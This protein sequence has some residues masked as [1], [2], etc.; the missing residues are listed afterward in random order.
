MLFSFWQRDSASQ[1][2]CTHED[3]DE[4]GPQP[5]LL[6]FDIR[7]LDHL[8]PRS[9]S[10][11]MYFVAFFAEP[12]KVS[13]DSFLRRSCNSG[14]RRASFTSALIFSVMAFSVAGG[15]TIA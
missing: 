5:G 9:T 12:P 15:A 7:C 1:R 6:Q 14:W 3:Q 4:C 11:R 8:T 2:D 10:S 13:A